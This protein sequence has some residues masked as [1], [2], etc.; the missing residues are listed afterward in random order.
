MSVIW[1]GLTEEGAVVPIQVTAEGKVVAVGD[2]PEGEFLKLT[3]GNLTGNLTVSTDKITLNATDGSISTD[4]S[5]E[6]GSAEET[7]FTNG[8]LIQ[9][10]GVIGS[11]IG[12][13]T[14]TQDQIFIYNGDTEEF[15]AC[16][17]SDGSA[18]FAKEMGV[19]PTGFVGPTFDYSI[20]YNAG[21]IYLNKKD[22]AT[23]NPAGNDFLRCM[24]DSGN[25][26]AHILG[27]GSASFAD[28]TCGFTADGELIF[29]SRGSRYKMFVSNGVCSA[30]V[31]TRQMELEEK[32]EQFDENRKEPRKDFSQGEGTSQVIITPDNDNAS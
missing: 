19:T 26:V 14:A 4:G 12:E 7:A 31:Y 6:V 23:V 16:L 17:K 32:A 15:P 28:D 29:T 24:Q 13:S 3:G 25:I 21:Q 27:D 22:N 2:G 1:S 10:V 5:I 11:Y 30:E 8:V 20:V 18:S 9:E